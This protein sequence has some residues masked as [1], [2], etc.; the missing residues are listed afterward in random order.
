M[1][2]EWCDWFGR[3]VN[4]GMGGRCKMCGSGG[5]CCWHGCRHTL[6]CYVLGLVASLLYIFLSGRNQGG[7]WYG[8]ARAKDSWRYC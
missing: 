5:L 2:I 3:W 6:C 4:C 1:G 8:M 7:H